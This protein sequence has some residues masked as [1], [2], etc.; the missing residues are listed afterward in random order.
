MRS[1]GAAETIDH[2]AVNLEDA[3]RKTHHDGIDVLMDL[4]S[5][6]EGFAKLAALV[7]Q[8][9]TAVTTGYVAD[10][11]AL[12][13]AHITGINFALQASSDLLDRLAKSLVRGRILAPP[14]TQISLNEAPSVLSGANDRPV[15]GK[16]VIAL[17][18]R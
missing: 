17:R 15:E 6:K 4:V 10:T 3:V 1:Y 9:G 13:S 14:I 16:T 2:T 12:E 18:P 5:D 8:G 7:R 11:G